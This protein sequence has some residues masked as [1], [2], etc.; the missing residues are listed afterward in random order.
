MNI[1]KIKSQ[2]QSEI[3]Q[4]PRKELQW[5]AKIMETKLDYKGGWYSLTP[6]QLINLLKGELEELEAEIIEER[7]LNFSED[8]NIKYSENPINIQDAQFECA[9]IANFCMMLAD[10]LE[11]SSAK[12]SKMKNIDYKY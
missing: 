3:V 6:L 11:N 9:N 2:S 12:Y 8:S 1:S 5:F 7:M 10:I 4:N